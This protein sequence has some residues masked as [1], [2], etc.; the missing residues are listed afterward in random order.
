MKQENQGVTRREQPLMPITKSVAVRTI[1]E[2]A[3]FC[4][5]YRRPFSGHNHQNLYPIQIRGKCGESATR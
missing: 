4:Y 2:L 3:H 1:S 5:N